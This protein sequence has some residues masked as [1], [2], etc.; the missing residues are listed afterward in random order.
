MPSIGRNL[1]E[2][3]VRLGLK[4]KD[5]ED[6]AER[7]RWKLRELRDAMN[8]VGKVA[9]GVA[10]AVGAAGGALIAIVDKAGAAAR[11]IRNLSQV[12]NASTKEFQKHAAAARTVGI[13]GEKLADIY[14]DMNDRVGDFITTGAGPM[15][16]FFEKIA[17]QVG[18]TAE[19]FA[20]L[21]G[22]EA[23]E[24]F[25]KSLEA[26]NVGQQE[27][28]FYM[29]AIASDSTRLLPLLR[30]NAEQMKK[31]G[32]EAERSGEIL[33]DMDL[34][35]L[36]DAKRRIDDLKASLGAQFTK[37][38][39]ENA[40]EI[41]GMAET[42][43]ELAEMALKATTQLLKFFGVMKEDAI[44][45]RSKDLLDIQNQI[46]AIENGA[47]MRRREGDRERVAAEEKLIEL[48][49][50]EADIQQSLID[51]EREYVVEIKEAAAAEE[52]AAEARA[53]A[54]DAQALTG[55]RGVS[56]QVKGG[57]G[58][59]DF[60]AEEAGRRGAVSDDAKDR[61]AA[62]RDSLKS[63]AELEQEFFEARMETLAENFELRLI[64]KQEFDALEEA[65][66]SEHQDRLSAIAEQGLSKR[67]QFER[68]SMANRISFVS[69]QLSRMTAGVSS[70]N[71]KLFEV[72]KAAGIANAIVATYQGAAEALKLGPIIGPALAAAQIAAGFA[73]VNAIKSQKFGASG[74][75]APSL[76]G[77]TAAPAVSNVG[78]GGGGQVVAIEGLDPGSLFSGKAVRELLEQVNEAVGDGGRVVFGS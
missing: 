16:D 18:V 6:G 27:M 57:G 23:L 10:V 78:P 26:A 29:E 5:L 31:L 62:L 35:E 73:Q 7:S 71:K 63:E 38:I 11:E 39:A 8:K 36:D 15:V 42:F 70:E 49:Q 64:S 33:S 58:G 34:K 56:V 72:N 41:A 69:S 30:N 59:G 1:G 66:E 50:R 68:M 74:G 28:T 2:L 9:G 76:A 54:A 43:G 60:L 14:K 48:K 19:Q 46:Y 24:L 45:E 12:A 22:P 61:L 51:L 37:I 21:S 53:A 67:E 13:E 75:V 32:D 47:A 44:L 3:F 52:A 25:V 65:I 4:T 55:R 20:K 17:P 40:D 77:G